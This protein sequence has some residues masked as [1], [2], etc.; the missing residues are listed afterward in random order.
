MVAGRMIQWDLP[1]L[2]NQVPGLK[3]FHYPLARYTSF[4]IGGPADALLRVEAVDVLR[5]V[6]S[7]ARRHQIPL[8]ILGGGSNLLIRD[9]GIR[10]IVVVLR[11]AFR[12]YQV[13]HDGMSS[14]GAEAVQKIAIQ[15]ATTID[16][17]FE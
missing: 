8:F 7:L 2:L 17:R 3:R 14:A 4:R 9:G 13:T 12:A 16:G 15:I 6:Q 1:T 5:Q 10:G 11:G